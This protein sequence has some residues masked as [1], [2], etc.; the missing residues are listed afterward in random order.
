MRR[1]GDLP[2]CRPPGRPA[3]RGACIGWLRDQRQAE[4]ERAVPR[5]GARLPSRSSA[6]ATVGRTL[7][8]R[9]S[10]LVDVQPRLLQVAQRARGV[11]TLGDGLTVSMYAS[12]LRVQRQDQVGV[13]DGR[14]GLARLGRARP[15]ARGMGPTGASTSTPRRQRA[16]RPRRGVGARRDVPGRG[17]RRRAAVAA[18]HP[19]RDARG[20]A[21]RAAGHVPGA[22]LVVLH[23]A[24]AAARPWASRR[25]SPRGNLRERVWWAAPRTAADQ[26]AFTTLARLH[27]GHRRAVPDRAG[28][29]PGPAQ[30][31]TRVGPDVAPVDPPGPRDP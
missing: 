13:R 24:R 4:Q 22:D 27:R 31:N 21:G 12:G 23:A 17:V 26:P 15:P 18:A 29:A 25:G 8:D 6:V 2:P 20:A 11:V 10:S 30:R 5:G 1:T 19:D 3:S 7:F 28:P 16:D 14:A 9:R